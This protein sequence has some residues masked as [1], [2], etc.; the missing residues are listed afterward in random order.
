MKNLKPLIDLIGKV[1][2]FAHDAEQELNGLKRNK[3]K[4][5]TNYA[6]INDKGELEIRTDNATFVDGI[7]HTKFANR[8]FEIS[9]E[10][11]MKIYALLQD[12][13]ITQLLNVRDDSHFP[14][15]NN[16]VIVGKDVEK[17]C[18]MDMYVKLLYE[19]EEINNTRHWWERKI[20]ID[21]EL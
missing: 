4:R 9:G 20:K 3:M 11:L 1:L 10:D 13:E 2:I 15:I 7:T 14:T 12:R 21:S 17:K 16:Y 19:V 5:I 6:T 8:T 18:L